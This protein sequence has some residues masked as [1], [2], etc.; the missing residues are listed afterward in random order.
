MKNKTIIILLFALFPLVVGLACT[1]GL[2]PLGGD[3]EGETEE[4]VV[5]VTEEVITEEPTEE[6]ATEEEVEPIE[7]EAT[8]E[9]VEPTVVETEPLTPEEYL[10]REKDTWD[11]TEEDIY[12]GFELTNQTQD[13]TLTGV[14]YELKLLDSTGAE[15]TSD[16]NTFPY[17]FPGQTLGVFFRTSISEEDPPVADVEISHGFEDSISA[18]GFPNPLSVDKV[19]LWEDDYWPIG[20]GVVK[21]ADTTTYTDI[22]VSLLCYNAAGEIVGGG[23]TYTEFVPGQ[24][25]TGFHTYIDTYDSVAS[26][27]AFPMLTYS[28]NEY[29]ALADFTSRASII[30]DNFYVR[31]TDMLYGGLVVQ[32]NL[33]EDILK[34]AILTITFY[35]EAGYVTSYGYHNIDYLFPGDT[36]GVSMYLSPQP[37]GSASTDYKAFILAGELAEDYELTSNIFQV[38]STEVTGEYNDDVKVNFTNTY[39]K[40]VTDVDLYVLVYDEDGQIIG[41]GNTYYDEPIPAGGTA[42]YEV[43]VYYAD[44]LTVSKIDAWVLPSYWTEFE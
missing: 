20:T 30:A 3:K 8:E 28:T 41:G 7:T 37:T 1:C 31:S 11:T 26:V 25:Q 14:D 9:E 4:A 21:N 34:D 36:L 43:Y 39:T 6:I 44:D 13:M 19:K 18:E 12:V 5:V 23:Y 22:R 33:T 27:E 29:A 35:D 24:D 15:I 17:L 40:S 16:W 2:L 38:N 42:E 32:N 10:I